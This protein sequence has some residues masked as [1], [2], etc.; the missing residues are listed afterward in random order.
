MEDT[1]QKERSLITVEDILDGDR[2]SR[3]SGVIFALICIIAIF[4]TVVFG[5]VD[6]AAWMIINILWAMTILLWCGESWSRGGFVF[7]PDPLY[8]PLLGL[9]AVGFIQLL[10]LAASS[11]EIL[12]IGTDRA[13]SLEPHATRFFVMRLIVYSTFFAACLTFI[14]TEK[15]FKRI[16][17]LIVSFASVMAFFGILQW[18]ANPE[19]IYGLRGTPQARPFGPFVNQHHF[20]AFMIMSGGVALGLLLGAKTSRDRRILLGLAIVVMGVAVVLTSSR[21]GVLG[22]VTMLAAASAAAYFTGRHTSDDVGETPRFGKG[23]LILAGVA[24]MGAVILIALAVGGNDSLFRGLGIANADADLTSGRSRFWPIALKIFLDHP[25]LGAG[26]DAFGVAFTKYDT[27]SGAFRVEQ[28]HNEYLQIL[29]DA[30]IAGFLCVLS[31]IVLLFKKGV[32]IVRNAGTGMRRDGAIGALAGIAGVLV[33]SFFDFPLRTPSNAFFFLILCAIAVVPVKI[34]H[35]HH[36]RHQ[37][38]FI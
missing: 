1:G 7:R 32:A 17:F 20:A 25:I 11:N 14:N 5:G 23:K 13:L 34:G 4:A 15:R 9:I 31:F 35:R 36:H 18:L 2:V 38:S 8:L 3:K 6:N 24:V 19:G 10:P 30:G 27:S 37:R 12:T 28:A 16:L 33:H 29:A 26:F 21:G 22:F